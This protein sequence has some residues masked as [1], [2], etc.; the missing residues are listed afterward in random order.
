MTRKDTLAQELYE[1]YCRSAGWKSKFTGDH[2]PPW[3]MVDL[4]TQAHWKAVAREAK[5]HSR[6]EVIR[7]TN[8]EREKHWG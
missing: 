8:A 7:A 6:K 3:P 1:A 4:E 2:L 5:A